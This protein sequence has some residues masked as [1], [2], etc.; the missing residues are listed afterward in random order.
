MKIYSCRLVAI[1]VSMKHFQ[2]LSITDRQNINRLLAKSFYR[3]DY[4]SSELVFENMF[5]WN[6]RGQIEVMWLSE[7]VALIRSQEKGG[8]WIFFPPVCRNE[9]EF[10]K[11][12][13][14]VRQHY[15]DNL[16]CGLSKTMVEACQNLKCLFLYDDYYSEYIYDPRELSEM[17]GGKFAR[18]RNQIAQF[19]KRYQFT[20]APYT[21]EHL[22]DVLLFL[23][24]YK[25]QG[26]STE[27]FEAIV[28]VLK[29]GSSFDYVCD[30][31]IA[32][33]KIIGL[34]IGV[35]SVFGHAV[36]MF[37]KSDFDYIGSGAALVQLTT[38]KHYAECKYLTRQ[39]DLGLPQLRKAKLSLNPIAKERKYACVFDPL[40]IRLHELYMQTFDDSHDY[41]DFFFLHSY[42]TNNT[43]YVQK[44][45]LVVS[46]LHVLAKKMIFNDQIFNLP[47]IVAASTD[48]N[49]RR[50]GLMREVM[51]KTFAGLLEQ[52]QMVVALYPT[53]PAFYYPYGFVHYA[54]S[55]SLSSYQEVV[56]CGL[57]QTT[58][59]DLLADMYHHCIQNDEGFVIRDKNYYENY[60]N[61]LWQ[62][63]VVFDL[64]KHDQDII[65]YVAHKDGEVDEILLC[66][67]KRPRHKDIDFAKVEMPHRD[68]NTP[69]N[70]IRIIDIVKLL[71]SLRFSNSEKADVTISIQDQ[72]IA[73]NNV[74]IRLV[75]DAGRIHAFP[76]EQADIV[77][78]IEEMTKIIF[79]Q[80]VDAKLTFLS[81]KKKLVCFDK[82]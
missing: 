35:I 31:L 77:I 82:F 9:I 39:E 34:S 11:A 41:V 20:F 52:G 74:T 70:M 55:I 75:L 57:E 60:L 80:S 7:D 10:I 37:E 18:K 69:T 13:D 16:V 23:S 66:G 5:A 72:F 61:S 40:K 8:N 46:A 6:F 56:D 50:Q 64:I 81:P 71:E 1:M 26:G 4:T 54:H 28:H 62:D 63:G 58:D 51:S 2:Q 45:G 27:D 14:F 65:G 17:K 68:G 79:G 21:K 32:D 38:S 15:P 48:V 30:L 19:H 53:D 24:R 36:I 33:E 59:C 76:F 43:Y 22:S 29:N 25:E 78:T 47:F 12:M 49:F 73:S 3:V 44:D 42:Q 67:T